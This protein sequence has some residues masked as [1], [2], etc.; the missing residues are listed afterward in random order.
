MSLDQLQ[1]T[2]IN[3]YNNDSCSSNRSTLSHKEKR[4]ILLAMGVGG[5]CAI[6]VCV[7]ALI[8][9]KFF[10][11]YRY[12]SH[13]L[14]MY[15]V[16]AAVFF[17]SV[18][19]LEMT[20]IQY[21]ERAYYR[22]L[23]A[24]AG[25]LLEYAVWVKLLFMFCLTFHLFCFAVFYRNFEKLEVVYIVFSIIGPLTFCWIP[26]VHGIYGEA[27]AWCWIQNWSND[28]ANSKLPEGEIEEYSLL[29]GPAFIGLS[30]SALAVFFI[31][32][33]LA[34]RAYF[35][36]THSHDSD[37]S[38]SLLNTQRR[39]VLR[40]I[41]P[42]VAYPILFFIFFAPSFVNRIR[43]T[44][45]KEASFESFMWSAITTPMLSFFAGVT[46]IVHI[47]VL[48]CRKSHRRR[49]YK[50]HPTTPVNIPSNMFTTETIASTA[51]RSVWEP[52]A[53]SDID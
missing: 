35:F 14:A 22:Y 38:T 7:V 42:L 21:D 13:R 8:M 53:E 52:P 45:V 16:L 20:F 12:L 27:G 4:V 1:D 9:V 51:G 10:K 30:L 15:Q 31:V 41:A 19:A 25:F 40:E 6:L 2:T 36:R 18:C 23:C 44:I 26:F 49:K 32:V 3:E 39:K 11:L 28:C 47:L 43:G 24:I 29:Y 5:V 17:G 50:G 34:Y 48:E 46:L 33:V 37:E